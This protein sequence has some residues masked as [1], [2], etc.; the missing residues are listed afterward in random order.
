[1]Y[2]MDFKVFGYS[3]AI[4]ER[5]DLMPPCQDR[6]SQLSASKFDKWSRN[7]YVNNSGRRVSQVNLLGSV[8]SSVRQDMSRRASMRSLK[9]SLVHLNKD[10]I[11]AK[12]AGQRTALGD[13]DSLADLPDAAA[14]NSMMGNG[15]K[16]D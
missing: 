3:S 16:Q 13:D 9:D 1:M 2:G 12:V 14:V 11:L 7:S 5:P 6:R 8:K 4:T 15:F 10:E